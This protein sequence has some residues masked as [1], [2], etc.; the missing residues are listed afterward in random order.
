MKHVEYQFSE[1][2]IDT[3]LFALAHLHLLDNGEISDVQMAINEQCAISAAEKLTRR[4]EHLT[5]NEIRVLCC[6]I[7]C[8]NLIC[9]GIISADTETHKECM[10]YMFSLNKLDKNLSSQIF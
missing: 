1:S 4:D 8:C 6:C 10:K 7:T 5:N 2:D 9:Q 3:C